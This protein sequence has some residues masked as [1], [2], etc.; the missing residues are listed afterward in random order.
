MAGKNEGGAIPKAPWVIGPLGQRLTLDM[1]PPAGNAH[2]LPMRKAEVVAA[3]NG[4]LLTMEE[5]LDR[6]NMTLE[7]LAGWLRAVERFGLNGL[8]TT[9]SLRYRAIQEKE[10]KY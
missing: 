5:A 9:R 3:V 10:R 8:R 2:W 1:L 7:E 6:Y 4:G